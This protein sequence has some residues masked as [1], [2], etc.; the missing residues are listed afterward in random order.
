MTHMGL[1]YASLRKLYIDKQLSAHEIA[2]RF[3]CSESKVNYW[4]AKYEIPKRSIGDA[5]YAKHNPDG[6]PFLMK[7]ALTPKEE[8]LM[9]LGLGLY[10]GEGHKK[11][12][13]SVRLGNTDPRLLKT[14]VDFLTDICGVKR[15][16]IG[17]RL[18]IFSDISE[19]SAKRFWIRS[20][21]ISSKQIKG[22]ATVIRSGRIGTYRQ[23]A[24]NGVLILEY[25]NRRLRD[26]LCGMIEKL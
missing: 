5:I 2:R 19:N 15:D 23:K 4:L 24:K 8:K 10:W 21:A 9:G 26:I 6:D 3:S 14:F 1:S 20:L 12:K 16:D 18:M 17:F 13:V 22:K 7:C 11:N 25:H